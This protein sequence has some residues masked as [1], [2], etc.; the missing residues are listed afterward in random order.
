[1]GVAYNSIVKIISNTKFVSSE[2][3]DGHNQICST[4]VISPC[5]ALD[6]QNLI[7]WHVSVAVTYLFCETR[8]LFGRLFVVVVEPFRSPSSSA[9]MF[10]YHW[11]M[12]ARRMKG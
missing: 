12:R 7:C 8:I 4:E 10:V 9:R 2:C 6:Q 5:V 3:A 11:R 1:M